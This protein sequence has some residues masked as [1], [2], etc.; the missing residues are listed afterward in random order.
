MSL[1]AQ[2]NIARLN[3]PWDDPGFED[4][5][6]ALDPVNASAEECPGFVWRLKSA[7]DDS[8]EMV[9][10]EEEGWL[11]N[12]TVWRCVK[13]LQD[14]VR[15]AGHL[16]IMRRRAEWFSP[17]KANLVLWWIADGTRPVFRDAMQK[18]ELLLRLGPTPEAFNF[19]ETFP[20]VQSG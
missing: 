19:R 20:P 9:A 8:P 1:L 7:A 14:F 4:F 16:S 5:Q 17:V 6:R 13:D 12:L 3:V 18:R 15:S 11:V 2:L 10:F